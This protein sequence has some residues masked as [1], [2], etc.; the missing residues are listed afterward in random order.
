MGRAALT[1]LFNACGV[2]SAASA[3]HSGLKGGLHFPYKRDRIH[4]QQDRIR[5]TR[6][7]SLS[8]STLWRIASRGAR[9]CTRCGVGSGRQSCRGPHRQRSRPPGISHRQGPLR[10]RRL[11]QPATIFSPRRQGRILRSH[12]GSGHAGNGCCRWPQ[13]RRPTANVDEGVGR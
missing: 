11:D 9:A 2:S 12:F 10:H 7:D 13:G 1:D 3:G 5:R 8:R 6:R 4:R